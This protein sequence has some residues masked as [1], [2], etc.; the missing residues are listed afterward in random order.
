MSDPATEAVQRSWPR[1]RKLVSN[2]PRVYME[3]AAREAVKPIRQLHKPQWNNCINACCSGEQCRHRNQ[4]CEHDYD[5]WPCDTAKLAYTSEE[6][7]AGPT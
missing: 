2:R 3:V 6:V 7:A 4:V 1:W 5:E